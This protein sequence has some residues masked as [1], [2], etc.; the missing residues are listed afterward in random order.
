[1]NNVEELWE[2][3]LDVIVPPKVDFNKRC[4]GAICASTAVMLYR[5]R[6]SVRHGQE[7][8][9]AFMEQ[10]RTNIDILTGDQ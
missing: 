9:K 4:R 7:P 1:M 10:I 8:D 5:C 6:E 3:F 2:E